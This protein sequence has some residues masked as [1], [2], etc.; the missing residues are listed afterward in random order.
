MAAVGRRA[1]SR[2]AASPSRGAASWFLVCGVLVPGVR[3]PGSVFGLG[4][5]PRCVR[6]P[7][8]RVAILGKIV[9]HY[10]YI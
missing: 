4:L 2:C 10:I 3:R 6:A 7:W 5:R 9:I 8:S 1:A